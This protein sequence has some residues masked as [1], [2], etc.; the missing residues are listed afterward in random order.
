[1]EGIPGKLCFGYKK[2]NYSVIP[3][4]IVRWKYAFNALLVPVSKP[5]NQNIL[6]VPVKAQETN[7]SRNKTMPNLFL[8]PKNP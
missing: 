2:N 6:T 1:M 5:N 8:S 4:E 3:L 7:V